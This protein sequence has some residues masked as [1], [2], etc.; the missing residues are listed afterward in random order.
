MEV[1]HLAQSEAV[2]KSVSQEVNWQRL[3]GQYKCVCG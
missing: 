1:S 3:G 2:A